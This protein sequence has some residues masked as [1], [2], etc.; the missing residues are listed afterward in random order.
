MSPQ[1][2][3]KHRRKHYLVKDK[4]MH[5][6]CLNC[7]D[8]GGIHALKSLPCHALDR[9][10]LKGDGTTKATSLRLPQARDDELSGGD[11]AASQAASLRLAQALQ[12]EEDELIDQDLE[13]ELLAEQ[14]SLEE[15]VLQAEEGELQRLLAQEEAELLQAK[16]ESL[17][18]RMEYVGE[19]LPPPGSGGSSSSRE[20][21]KLPAIIT[22]RSLEHE[23]ELS[24]GPKAAEA[25]RP[26]MTHEAEHK[27]SQRA[28]YVSGFMCVQDGIIYCLHSNYGSYPPKQALLITAIAEPRLG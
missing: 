17:E 1:S 13:A 14:L 26:R 20:L 12:A 3:A 5:C 16:M 2:Q 25:K 9:E 21:K 11:D 6:R 28:A 24:E 4:E 18:T 27:Q 15:L 19:L 23:L 7:G 10:L 8:V 22:K